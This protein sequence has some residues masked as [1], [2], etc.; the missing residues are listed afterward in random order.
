[1]TDNCPWLTLANT[2]HTVYTQI[3]TIIL[4]GCRVSS[5][6]IEATLSVC[7]CL[8]PKVSSN[9]ETLEEAVTQEGQSDEQKAGSASV[10]VI[11][12]LADLQTRNKEEWD[13]SHSM[14]I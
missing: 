3:K 7:P 10:D 14:L 1:M 12:F 6:P 5:S 2:P 11:D 4:Y 8:K 9:T 13:D